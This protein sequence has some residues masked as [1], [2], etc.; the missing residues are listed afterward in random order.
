MVG[1]RANSPFRLSSLNPCLR[2]FVRLCA[3]R[4]YEVRGAVAKWEYGRD[5]VRF[6]L[7][8]I[9]YDRISLLP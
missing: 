5:G 3:L 8:P 9:L 4:A 7:K 1:R 6:A 2:D